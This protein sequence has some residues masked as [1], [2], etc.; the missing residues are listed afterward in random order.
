MAV[1]LL[2]LTACGTHEDAKTGTT[3]SATETATASTSSPTAEPSTSVSPE[4]SASADSAV[5]SPAV[6]TESDSQSD[7][8]VGSS[9]DDTAGGKTAEVTL[10]VQVDGTAEFSYSDNGKL[11]REDIAEGFTRTFTIPT[12]GVTTY[13][14]VDASGKNA[15]ATEVICELRYNDKVIASYSSADRA[16]AVKATCGVTGDINTMAEQ[17]SKLK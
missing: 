6:E 2:A 4:V 17:P 5:S 15:T 13:Y 11:Q 9:D 14:T 3:P 12:A 1:V 10:T 8:S 7:S 16:D